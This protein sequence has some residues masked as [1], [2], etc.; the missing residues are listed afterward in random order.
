MTSLTDDPI[1]LRQANPQSRSTM[2]I[3][4]SL[5]AA[6]KFLVDQAPLETF[7]AHNTLQAFEE[8]P[9]HQAV[10]LAGEMYGANGYLSEAEFQE[11]HRRGEIIN[12]DLE[13][14]KLRLGWPPSTVTCI[15]WVTVA[16]I[17]HA[18]LFRKEPRIAPA[19]RGWWLRNCHPAGE[20]AIFLREA[21]L[22]LPWPAA[23]DP[24]NDEALTPGELCRQVAELPLITSVRSVLVPY[25][26]R[27]LDRG[28]AGHHEP[29]RD[30]FWIFFLAR[31]SRG[32]IVASFGPALEKDA[33]MRIGV[34]QS[35]VQAV[36]EL[37]GLSES[38]P[39][40]TEEAIRNA[41]L[42][43]PGWAAMFHRLERYP[44]ERPHF[45]TPVHLVDYLAVLL[46]VEFHLARDAALKMGFVSRQNA[47]LPSTLGIALRQLLKPTA[48]KT[49]LRSEPWELCLA[50]LD[51]GVTVRT[52]ENIDSMAG[53]KALVDAALGFGRWRRL[54]LWQEALEANLRNQ[55]LKALAV[56]PVNPPRAGCQPILEVMTCLDDREESFR[57]ALEEAHP[58]IR[59]WGAPGFFQLPVAYKDLSSPYP[60][61]L[62]PL[63]VE[64]AYTVREKPA[65]DRT[66]ATLQRTAS[67]NRVARQAEQSLRQKTL[68]ALV[69]TLGAVAA[70][71]LMLFGVFFPRWRE[72][73]NRLRASRSDAVSLDLPESV[74]GAGVLAF[75]LSDQISRVGGLLRTIGLTRDF[76][77][78]VIVLGHGS[79]STNNPHKS[80][81][82]CGACRGHEGHNNA[83]LLAS[84]ANRVEVREALAKQGLI[85]PET[86]WFVGGRHDTC[87]GSVDLFDTHLVPEGLREKLKQATSWVNEAVRADAVERCRRFRSAP[88]SPD[89]K[90]AH[91]HVRERSVDPAQPRPEMGHMTNA[92]VI[93]GRRWRTRGLFLDRRSFLVSYDPDQDAEG[94]IIGNILRAITPI[95][96][97]IN[98]QYYF[99]RVDPIRYGSGSKLPHN[100][101]SLVGV[102]EGALGDLRTGLPRQMVELHTPV[103]LLYLVEAPVEHV[104][105]ALRGNPDL[106]RKLA[107]QWCTM[108][109]LDPA[110]TREWLIGPDLTASEVRFQNG[111]PFPTTPDSRSWFEGKAGNL[112]LAWIRNPIFNEVPVQS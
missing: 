23:H 71:P 45:E 54:A 81:Y 41:L 83:R 94:I 33:R 91:R 99:S 77:P 2:V 6:A 31:V 30:R 39:E 29:V 43:H 109:V 74:D 72:H 64:P 38:N 106:R 1:L 32:G 11:M 57:R 14:A 96:V 85:I 24:V 25:F 50:L 16:K 53:R 17:E 65:S 49:D 93:V 47:A 107:N 66:A 10:R 89:P 102:M 105:A 58:E 46:L 26:S 79:N 13:Q 7:V 104:L 69:G 8:A 60:R 68:G 35:P 15:P 36:L 59:T 19:S 34:G 110:S 76:A 55:L 52:L 5:R 27:Y 90:S 12:E 63:G 20:A 3:E 44:E 95:V 22:G 87:S 97:G 62:C 37:L 48:K 98:L 4:Q 56:K 70:F 112:P 103:R 100:P 82:D 84:L 78:L 67:F 28:M 40:V 111:A 51:L 80:A 75:P 101:V 21:T 108:A 42:R 18:L 73:L 86:T 92:M 61:I 9:F 88:G